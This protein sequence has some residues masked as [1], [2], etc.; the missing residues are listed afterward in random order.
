MVVLGHVDLEDVCQGAEV[1][2]RIARDRERIAPVDENV[3]V[4]VAQHEE[5]DRYIE[6]AEHQG[7]A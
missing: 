3:A 4:R 5:R 7:A 2:A 1:C 6:A